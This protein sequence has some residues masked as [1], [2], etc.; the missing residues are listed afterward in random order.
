MKIYIDCDNSSYN[1]EYEYWEEIRNAIIDSTYSYL[2]TLFLSLE[3]GRENKKN[4]IE[5]ILKYIK[6]LSDPKD[7]PNII[8]LYRIPLVHIPTPVDVMITTITD[9]EIN[10]F[11]GVNII[12]LYALCNKSENEG[13]YSVGNS[14][15]ICNLLT[16][17]KPFIESANINIYESVIQI[18]KVFEKSRISNK[19]VF[20][21]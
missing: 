14:H 9:K 11:I 19:N 16:L 3:N 13:Y 18:E 1:C 17:I 4:D 2:Q 10:L 15:D 5:Y 21:W 20:I 7:L 12:G 8:T 6:T